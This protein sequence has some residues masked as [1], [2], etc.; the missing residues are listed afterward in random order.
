MTD[1]FTPMRPAIPSR[2]TG[3]DKP[4]DPMKDQAEELKE[5]AMRGRPARTLKANRVGKRRVA[6]RHHGVS[7][8]A[9]ARTRHFAVNKDTGVVV[10][11][12]EEDLRAFAYVTVMFEKMAVPARKRALQALQKVYG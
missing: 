3:K 4:F 12:S 5:P 8:P 9:P 2:K 10:E 7:P 11:L 1:D 6:K